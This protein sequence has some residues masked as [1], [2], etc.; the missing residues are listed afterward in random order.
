MH[1]SKVILLV[2][3]LHQILGACTLNPIAYRTPLENYL[4]EADT[5]IAERRYTE[6]V[7][8]LED[9]AAVYPDSR[10]PLVRMG[11]IYL[12]QHRWLPA[13]DAF[14][15]ALAR[16][17][18]SGV[19]TAGLAEA[20]LNQGKTGQALELWQSAAELNPEIPGV[21]TGLGRTHLARLEFEAARQAFL[22][23]QSH[24]PDPEAQWFL[25]A[26][27]APLDVSAA[28]NYLLA[29]PPDAHPDVLARRDYLLATLVPF[30][31]E[32]PQADVGR[33]TGI[34]FTQAQLWPLA[35][36]NLNIAVESL[37]NSTSSTTAE[38]LAFL[39]HS[40]A[41][42][43]RPALDFFEQARRL[44]STSALPSYFYGIYL[45]QQGALNAAEEQFKQA[46]AL[47]SENAAVHIELARTKAEQGD[48]LAAEEHY[49][50]AT[51]AADDD[52]QM[53]L[54]Q[55]RFYATRGYRLVEAGIPVAEAIVSDYEDNAEAHDLLGWMHFLTGDIG[56]AQRSLEKA[57]ELE[58]D[59]ISA[60][61]HLARVLAAQNQV[62]EAAEAYRQVID[63]DTSGIFR[64][65]AL[66]ELQGLQ[67]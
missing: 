56:Q 1:A 22:D 35:I 9:A 61:Y 49:D 26:L 29:I 7:K 10:L 52:V 65:R 15:R 51:M 25:A 24:H 42:A 20:A 12:V 36:H 33:A 2:F 17:L 39:G 34:A 13:E 40:R 19:A 3:A 28:N 50:A 5:L 43:G 63:W 66:K 8:R 27:D 4:D 57:V 38:I 46:I 18:Q 59:L 60:R 58:P 62:S 41:Q 11:Q 47:D 14:N 48:F 55:A 67:P 21:F 44:D 37:Q 23:Q 30:T 31:A 45:R 6:A 64:D 16:D 32:S 54:A 53:R